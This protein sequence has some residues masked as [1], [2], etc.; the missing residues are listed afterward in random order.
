M[1]KNQLLRSHEGD[2]TET[3]QKL[4]NIYLFQNMGLLSLLKHFGCYGNLKFP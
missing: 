2:E 3:L 4:H 1:F